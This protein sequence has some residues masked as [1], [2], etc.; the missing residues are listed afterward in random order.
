MGSASHLSSQTLSIERVVGKL[1]HPANIVPW[2]KHLMGHLYT[3]LA[4]ALGQSKCHLIKSSRAF[5]N[6]LE[7]I[8]REPSTEEEA[9]ISSFAT[10]QA[11]SKIHHSKRVY[12]L[13]KTAVEEFQIIRQAMADPKIEKSCPIAHLVPKDPDAESSGDSSL[14]SAGGWSIDM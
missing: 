3:S 11:A 4:A 6:L 2:L 12:F 8:T 1:N 9:L 7:L 14:D 10:A 13:N 5:R